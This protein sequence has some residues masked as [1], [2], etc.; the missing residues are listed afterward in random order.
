M[1]DSAVARGERIFHGSGG[2]VACHGEAGGG[3][4]S[5]PALA[6]GIWLHGPDSYEA[7]R[8]RIIH[9]IP[10]RYSLRDLAMPMRGTDALSDDE[11][12]AVAAYVWVISHPKAWKRLGN[13]E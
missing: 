1:T 7:I 3:T 11:V 4:D 6:E 2:C 10:A 8:A 5:G 12:S 9:D 13:R